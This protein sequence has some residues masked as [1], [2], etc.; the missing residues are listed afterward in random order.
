MN[1][2]LLEKLKEK[3]KDKSYNELAQ[4]G[5][6]FQPEYGT[7]PN[8]EMADFIMELMVKKLSEM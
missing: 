1:K 5:T 2:D 6:Y 8:K 3:L 7:Q 4:F